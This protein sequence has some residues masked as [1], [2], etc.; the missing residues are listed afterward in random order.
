MKKELKKMLNWTSYAKISSTGSSYDPAPDLP[1]SNRCSKL[2]QI[3]WTSAESCIEFHKL[4]KEY[5]II[6]IGVRSKKLWSKHGEADFC[7]ASVHRL[8]RCS[9][10]GQMRWNLAEY[11]R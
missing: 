1:I 5:K 2:I 8:F 10:F 7:V 3:R 6:K 11:C 9:K 4:S